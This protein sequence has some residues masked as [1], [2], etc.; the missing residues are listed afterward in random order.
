[1]TTICLFYRSLTLK[2]I[3]NDQLT[4]SN[5]LNKNKIYHVIIIVRYLYK[6]YYKY[7]NKKYIYTNLAISLAFWEFDD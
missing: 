7:N 3:L 4:I 2:T 5:I 1:M 6:Y